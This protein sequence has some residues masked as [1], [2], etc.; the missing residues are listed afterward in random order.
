[1]VKAYLRYDAAGT[2]GV[3][4]SGCSPEFDA[5]GKQL[6]TASLENVSVW[7]VKQ[8]SLV[9]PRPRA[10]DKKPRG[11]GP[12]VL[13]SSVIRDKKRKSGSRP[14]GGDCSCWRRQRSRRRRRR[15]RHRRHRRHAHMCKRRGDGAGGGGGGGGA[16][17]VYSTSAA[18]MRSRR[19]LG[20]HNLQRWRARAESMAASGSRLSSL[21]WPGGC[22]TLHH[23]A[24]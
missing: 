20:R 22:L 19:W 16:L 10:G 5:T 17:D 6:F 4:T 23:S 24:L 11:E 8:G 12:G 2:F 21:A 7:N 13:E 18:G 3:V 1:M 9:R 14:R 15:C